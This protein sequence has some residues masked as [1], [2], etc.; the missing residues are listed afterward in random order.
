VGKPL[1]Y[2]IAFICMAIFVASFAVIRGFASLQ[3]VSLTLVAVSVSAAGLYLQW[4]RSRSTEVNSVNTGNTK[5]ALIWLLG[6]FTLSASV[7]LV[8]S[9]HEGWDIGDTIG[10]GFFLVFACLSIYE[11][12]RR[13]KNKEVK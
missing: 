13:T 10:L 1:P 5:R 4:K 12:L 2:L 6:L 7:A 3:E 11:L 9:I 8:R